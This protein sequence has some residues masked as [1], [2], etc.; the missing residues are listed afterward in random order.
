M[1][2]VRNENASH[3]EGPA[4]SDL[5][6]LLGG[7][8]QTGDLTSL[9]NKLLSQLGPIE[10]QTVQPEQRAEAEKLLA[11]LLNRGTQTGLSPQLLQALEADQTVRAQAVG[12]L[13][14]LTKLIT[15]L[16]LPAVLGQKLLP[17]LLEGILGKQAAGKAQSTRQAPDSTARP[18]RKT[19]P[20]KEA[21]QVPPTKP[22]SEA[23]ASSSKRKK[24]ATQPAPE[25]TPGKKPGTASSGRSTKKPATRSTSGTQEKT[26]PTTRSRKST[27]RRKSNEGLDL[28]N[29][30]EQLGDA[31][32][33]KAK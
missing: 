1:N 2:G 27:T 13:P 28:D 16:G 23:A 17:M 5:S 3:V 24:P 26:Q 31:L 30:L 15:G 25:S 9:A 22:A 6:S 32:N 20:K 18:K 10:G 21:G 19:T 14:I 11:G 7:L 29:L 8:L 4:K 12:V 33:P